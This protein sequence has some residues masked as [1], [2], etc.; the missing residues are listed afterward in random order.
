MSVFF[1]IASARAAPLHV[2][3]PARAYA[4]L[5]E[6]ISGGSVSIS[7]MAAPLSHDGSLA[8]PPDALVLCSGT[9][10]DA[11]LPDAA[12]RT[13]PRSTVVEVYGPSQGETADVAFPW[14]DLPAVTAFSRAIANEISRREPEAA[15]HVALN[16]MRLL[17]DFGTVQQR[18]NEI[19]KDYAHS[20][21][22]VADEFSRAVARQ[23]GFGTKGLAA[24][25]QRSLPSSA[26]TTAALE[27]AVQR[28]EG[29]IFLYDMDV[30]RPAI[31][32]L[33]AA[34][35]DNGIP[36]V[37]LQETLPTGLHYQ[38]WAMRQWNTIHGALNEAAP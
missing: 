29:S 21:V 23:L 8:L 35:T 15:M 19:A 28:R 9:R 11:W 14:Y 38:T 1:A 7:L 18:I 13:A 16:L 17:N 34:A 2:V 10:A 20:D 24:H 26:S 32:E 5:A 25:D 22:I 27:D 37:A 12:L 3:V 33:I 4:D 36:V 6:T 31:K 30:A